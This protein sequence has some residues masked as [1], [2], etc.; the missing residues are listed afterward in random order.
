M[1][2]PA[3]NTHAAPSSGVRPFAL[4]TLALLAP[5]F[6]VWYFAAPLLLFPAFLILRA[7]AYLGFGGLVRGVE[8]SGAIV[9]FVTTLHSAG[10]GMAGL[11]TVDVNLLLYSFGLP[12]LAALTLAAH[13]RRY[14][15]HLAIGYAVLMPVVAFGAFA[16]FLKNVAITSGAAVASQTGFVAWQR[17]AI[18]F[19]FQFGSLILPAVTPA[20]LWIGMHRGFLTAVRDRPPARV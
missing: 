10:N 5:A 2:V 18:A 12:L 17:E 15:R 13:E 3:M 19:A 1:S 9:T 11:V 7:V 8:E 4:R 16:D 20:V 14:K 6:A